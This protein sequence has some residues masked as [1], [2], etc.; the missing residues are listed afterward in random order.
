MCITQQNA[1]P[2][3]ITTNATHST[4]TSYT[5]IGSE[6]RYVSLPSRMTLH[7]SPLLEGGRDNSRQCSWRSLRNEHRWSGASI[8]KFSYPLFIRTT[9]SSIWFIYRRMR[10]CQL[11]K[12]PHRLLVDTFSCKGKHV[13]ALSKHHA[14]KMVYM[15]NWRSA[16]SILEL[17]A[18]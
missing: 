12:N 5:G 17:D 14:V 13:C 15:D 3:R 1:C 10:L 8:Y 18:A 11:T 4:A 9:R 7:Q 2:V 16:P 6:A